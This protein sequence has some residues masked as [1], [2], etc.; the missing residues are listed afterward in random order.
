MI[1]RIASGAAGGKPG[2]GAASGTLIR[3]HPGILVERTAC[4]RFMGRGKGRQRQDRPDHASERSMTTRR[5]HK[6]PRHQMRSFADKSKAIPPTN[7]ST[8]I[9]EDN[10]R[11]KPTVAANIPMI[12]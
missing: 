7:N 2:D 1:K 11:R 3:K 5:N 8:P 12:T 6:R 9:P 10:I 4:R